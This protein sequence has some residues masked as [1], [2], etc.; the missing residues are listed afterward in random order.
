[1]VDV[2]K[3]IVMAVRRAGIYKKVTPILRYSFAAHLLENGTD[4]RHI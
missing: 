3:I 1:M 4:I 2:L